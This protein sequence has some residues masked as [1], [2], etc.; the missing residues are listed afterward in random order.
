MRTKD[1][2][3]TVSALR[4]QI[5][6]IESYASNMS[7]RFQI[8]RAKA[9]SLKIDIL[10]RGLMN[11]TKSLARQAGFSSIARDRKKLGI[12]LLAAAAGMVAGGVLNRNGLSAFTG[13]ML[14]FDGALQGF[15]S[16]KWAVSLDGDLQVIPRNQIVPGHTWVTLE[17]LLLA[18]EGL[19]TKAQAGEQ[20]GNVAA[21]IAE[22]KQGHSRLEYLL[23]VTQWVRRIE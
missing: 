22:L 4:Q 9:E 17:S 1:F 3:E 12:S 15:G 7:S 16:S 23:P 6:I 10:Q 19:R 8:L 21:I 18:F 11:R 13:G 5:T 14:S 20:F 2:N